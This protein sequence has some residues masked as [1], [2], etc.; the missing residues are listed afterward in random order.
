[1]NDS[2]TTTN[3]TDIAVGICYEQYIAQDAYV[4]YYSVQT[5]RNVQERCGFAGWKR[6]TRTRYS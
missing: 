1:M 6:C 4:T 2:N 3:G 5:S